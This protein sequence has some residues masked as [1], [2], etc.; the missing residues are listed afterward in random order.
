MSDTSV[1]CPGLAWFRRMCL[2]VALIATGAGGTLA[3]MHAQNRASGDDAGKDNAAKDNA[4]EKQDDRLF[5][6]RTY[7][8]HDGR[9][10]ALNARFRDHTTKLFEKHGMT[11]VGYWV[12]ASDSGKGGNTLVYILAYP[13][14]ESRDKSWKAFIADPEWK[15]AQAASEQD[16]PIVKEVESTFLSPTDYSAIK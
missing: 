7:I 10:D 16:G 1:C 11:N 3:L 4:A 9:L 6:M 13:D 15:K 5:E 14:R 8:T 2:G 12:L